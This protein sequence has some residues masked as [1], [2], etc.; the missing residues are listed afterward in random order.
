MAFTFRKETASGQALEPIRHG[1]Q[2][3]HRP[4]ILED[5]DP[6]E[7]VAQVAVIEDIDQRESAD[8]GF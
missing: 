7:R 8:G 6:L 5:A 1:F 3:L 2:P 4:P